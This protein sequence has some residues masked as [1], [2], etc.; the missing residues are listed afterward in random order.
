MLPMSHFGLMSI[1]KANVTQTWDTQ[2]YSW[3]DV[4]SHFLSSIYPYC[5]GLFPGHRP[6]RMVSKI[7]VMQ[8]SGI[9]VI[10]TNTK[11]KHELATWSKHKT[12]VNF[13]GYVYIGCTTGV[14]VTKAPF[15]NFSVS[16]ILDLAKA[17]ARLFQSHSYLTGVTAAQLQRHLSNMNVIFN[18]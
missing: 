15:V 14:G 18:S 7:P 11:T 4:V 17:P 1:H 3:G 5:G 13:F 2:F 9:R 8:F 10:S 12:F 16:R 6:K